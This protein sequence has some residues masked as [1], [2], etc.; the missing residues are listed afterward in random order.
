MCGLIRLQLL[1]HWQPGGRRGKEGA[2]LNLKNQKKKKEEKAAVSLRPD[3][4]CRCL[5]RTGRHSLPGPRQSQE[6]FVLFS[7]SRGFSPALVGLSLR[8]IN[9]PCNM[10]GDTLILPNMC[11]AFG[12]GQREGLRKERGRE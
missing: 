1:G 8:A 7:Y 4:F 5:A 3:L 11:G 2:N 10:R 9:T 12:G 6:E